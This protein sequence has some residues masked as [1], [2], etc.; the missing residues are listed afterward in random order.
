[1]IERIGV[2]GA[3]DMGSGVARALVRSGFTVLTDLSERSAATRQ[4]AR[5]AG[6][7]DLGSIERLVV[8]SDL[9]LSIMPPAAARDFAARS[10]AAIRATRAGTVFADC[11]AVSPE[12]L[13]AM[14]GPF[15]SAGV[16]FV[17]VGIVGRPPGRR[18]G[19]ATRFYVSGAERAALLGLA[20]E[21]LQLIDM[22]KQLGRASAI[23]MVYASLNKGLDALLTAVLLASESLGVRTEL[24]EEL[25]RSQ[26]NVLAR[27]RRR[28]PYLAA[29]AERFAP[30]MREIAATF[31]AAGVTPKFHEAAASIYAELAKTPLARE[32]RATLPEHRSLEEA[33]AVFAAVLEKPAGR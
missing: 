3:G 27:M 14:A 5:E 28:I 21:G 30:E 24:M 22:G 26:A 19:I 2:V 23:K 10:L 20:V 17:D 29:T 11:N 16:G 25:G 4:L 6:M 18:D 8:G 12:T 32:T 9:L 1:V 7:R 31:D 13:T 33:L 15:V